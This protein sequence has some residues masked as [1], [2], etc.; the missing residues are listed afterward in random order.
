[1]LTALS[2]YSERIEE[3]QI[4]K[5]R[6]F[7]TGNVQMRFTIISHFIISHFIIISHL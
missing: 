3:G 2:P 1:M 4:E 5:K 6:K 7:L